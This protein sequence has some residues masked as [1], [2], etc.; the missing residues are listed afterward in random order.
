MPRHT[1][2]AIA[3][4]RLKE[5]TCMR[6]TITVAFGILTLA[7]VLGASP[8]RADR[9]QTPPKRAGAAA[10][11]AGLSSNGFQAVMEELAPRFERA[12]HLKVVVAYDLASTHRQ[13]IE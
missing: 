11:S 13:R 9:D 3:F 8:L 12:K 2:T 5:G 1:R 10:Q 7:A 6:A 4:T